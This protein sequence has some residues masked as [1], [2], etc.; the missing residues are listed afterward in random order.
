MD[1]LIGAI[2][3]VAFNYAPTQFMPCDGAQLNISQNQALFALLGNTYGGDGKTT[4]ALPQLQAPSKGLQYI[5]C[6]QGIW[7]QRQ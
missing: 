5:I 1:E 6:V 2:K 7:P 3:L 4:F